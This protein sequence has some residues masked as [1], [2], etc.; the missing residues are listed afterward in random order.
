MKWG[1]PGEEQVLWEKMGYGFQ[2]DIHQVFGWRSLVDT[3]MSLEFRRE[4]GAAD[5][6]LRCQMYR[7]HLKLKPDT[8]TQGVNIDG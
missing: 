1:K 5:N 3:Y 7:C 8:T 2:T 4:I 6:N